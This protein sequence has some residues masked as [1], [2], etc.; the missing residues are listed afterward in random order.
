M[1]VVKWERFIFPRLHDC[2]LV[3]KRD[4]EEFVADLS[5]DAPWPWRCPLGPYLNALDPE[6]RRIPD[7][8]NHCFSLGVA[9]VFLVLCNLGAFIIEICP[10]LYWVTEIGPI[11]P[12][13]A[14]AG[15]AGHL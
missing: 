9:M 7:E 14:V 4:G 13:S 5:G 12:R 15:P 10:L 3:L 8:H 1:D 2:F 11:A 6:G